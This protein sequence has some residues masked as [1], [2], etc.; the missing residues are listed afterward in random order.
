[1]R[2]KNSDVV[3]A[4]I[5]G[6]LILGSSPALAET[7]T[8]GLDG[9]ADHQQ[10]RISEGVQSGQLTPGEFNRLQEEQTPTRGAEARMKT[11]G[12]LA[13]RERDRLN[14]M[15]DRSSRDIYRA[16]H[17]NRVAAPGVNWQGPGPYWGPPASLDGRE[18][19]QQNRINQGVQSRQLTPEEFNRLQRE[20]AR[21][22][23]AEA[24]MRA[25]GRLDPR[26]RAR[27]NAM[28]NRSGRDI[29]RA[30]HN[31]QVATPGRAWGQPHPYGGARP[32]EPWRQQ[33]NQPNRIYQGVRSGQ[34]AP[35]EFNRLGNQ[36][37]RI[38]GTEARMRVDGN[39]TPRGQGRLNPIVNQG[40]SNI[41]RARFNPRVGR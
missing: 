1:M 17:D 10:E 7:F 30:E 11:D 18:A 14:A 26:E 23:A 27:L 36:Q 29:Y 34:V 33:A 28:L 6:G 38:R 37:A 31:R 41:N 24:L 12:R 5:I 16:A 21:I 13:P 22:R 39:F 40:A 25:D 20:Q 3:T 19:Y 8:P 15:P 9:R 35:A 32:G 2:R 4:L